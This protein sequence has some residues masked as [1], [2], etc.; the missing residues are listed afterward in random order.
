MQLVLAK[1]AN[2][3]ASCVFS[4]NNGTG[5]VYTGLS[6]SILFSLIGAVGS[7]ADGN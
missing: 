6:S 3:A 1:G 2:S 7:S 4:I 5:G